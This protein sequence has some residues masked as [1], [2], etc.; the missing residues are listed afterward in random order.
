MKQGFVKVS[1]PFIPVRVA[2]CA[3]NTAQIIAQIKRDAAHG[4]EVLCT[5]ELCITGYSCGD[6]FAQ[7]TL[8]RAAEAALCEIAR[9]TRGIEMLC[10][11]GVPLVH[12]GKLYNCAA[13]VSAGRILG[14]VPKTHVPNYSEYYELRHFAP[15][16]CEN[17]ILLLEGV[18][19]PFGTKLLFECK[20]MAE[21]VV[22]AEICE[23]L[24]TVNPPSCAAAIAGATLIVNLS[25][26]D[27][28]LEKSEARKDLVAAHS[29]RI[30]AGYV[31]SN[32]GE[33]ES[34]TDMVFSGQRIIAEN[35]KVLMN[36]EPFK[37]CAACTDIDVEKLHLLRMRTNTFLQNASGYER[38]LFTLPIQKL[39]LETPIC[40]TPYWP[41]NSAQSARI[42]ANA[43]TI[44]AHGLAKRMAHTNAQS[45]VIGIS[46]GLDSCLALL[47]AVK[48]CNILHLPCEKILAVSM[49]CFGTSERTHRN[50]ALLCE[51][52]HVT[53]RVIP[54]TDT[55]QSHFADI[56]HSADNYN[57]TFENAQARVRTLVLMDLANETGGL[58]VGT[59]D[60]S[61][62]ALGWATFAGDHISMY[63]VNA[64]VPK[65]LVQ[66]IVEN[67]ADKADE[68][69]AAILRD[70]LATPISPEL[71]PGNE[72][73]R[74]ETEALVGPYALHDFFL[75][76]MLRY[77]FAPT[78]IFA[79]AHSAFADIYTNHDLLHWLEVFY[80]RFFAQQFKRSC[81]PD[82]P[83][84]CDISLSPRGDWKMPS[85]AI[86][87]LWLEE[88]ALLREGKA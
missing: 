43:L 19:V 28:T 39:R 70:I 50:A 20:G 26:S 30:C 61:E 68:P 76:Y 4:V 41:A 85:D 72:Q 2:D 38:I 48:A 36:T 86:A 53:L 33:G 74:Q 60:L 73:A 58:V 79:L 57:V 16:P 44:Q 77:G 88:I 83:K 31:Y 47:C 63:G 17:S 64:G 18:Q 42:F 15:A 71:L 6:L 67:A 49:P 23:D 37:A 55:V 21:L 7:K 10:F 87:T 80:R 59:G 81:M 5:P 9:A 25:A 22:G 56:Q 32:A 35:G 52:L 62:L 13:A 27:E 84:V 8:Q 12:L 46:G 69:L 24:W 66:K 65:T 75:Y 82:G 14:I 29:A 45:A 40:K 51:A 1:A 11:V 3:F 34:S 78:K 54:I